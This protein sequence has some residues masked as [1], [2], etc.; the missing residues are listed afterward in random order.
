MSEIIFKVFEGDVNYRKWNSPCK[1]YQE[2]ILRIANKDVSKR[3]KY[4][5]VGI[6]CCQQDILAFI[7]MPSRKIIAATGMQQSLFDPNVVFTNFISV[8]PDYRKMGFARK[9]VRNRF[10]WMRDNYK[11]KTLELSDFTA[12]GAIFIKPLIDELSKD[13]PSVIVKYKEYIQN[14]YEYKAMKKALEEKKEFLDI[15]EFESSLTRF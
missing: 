10:I 12:M 4:F 14:S 9:L 15:E 3:L 5:P 8:D 11:G 13:Y 6:S 1:L 2:Y 7:E